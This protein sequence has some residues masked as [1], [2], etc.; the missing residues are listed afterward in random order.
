MLLVVVFVAMFLYGSA[1]SPPSQAV[2]IA[3]LPFS[4]SERGGNDQYFVDGISDDTIASLSQIDPTHLRG[5]ARGSVEAAQRAWARGMGLSA[6]LR[7]PYVVQGR[8]GAEH[9]RVRITTALVRGKDGAEIWSATY[10]RARTELRGLQREVSM[11]IAGRVRLE[12]APERLA[13]LD[14]RQTANP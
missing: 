2:S 14:R 9:D 4:S 3:V 12:V 13:R 6:A 10:D 8:V 11:A 7:V 5:I 1:S